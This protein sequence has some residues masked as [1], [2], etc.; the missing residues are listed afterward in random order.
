MFRSSLVDE[1]RDAARSLIRARRSTFLASACLAI[2]L[3]A[4]AVM[5]G[6]VDALF[7]RPPHWGAEPRTG[8][9]PVFRGTCQRRA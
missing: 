7:L 4:S 6:V 1:C 3:G 5:F 2:G 8:D 9:T